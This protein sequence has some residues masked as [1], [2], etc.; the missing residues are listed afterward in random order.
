MVEDVSGVM[1]GVLALEGSLPAV[2]ARVSDKV[3]RARKTSVPSLKTT[4]MMDSPSMDSERSDSMSPSPL[5]MVSTGRVTRTSTCSGER[6]GAS[7]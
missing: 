1:R 5:I 2:S 7:V 6:P 3:W 4:V